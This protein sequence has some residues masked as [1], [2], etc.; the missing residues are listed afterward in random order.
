MADPLF[1]LAVVLF[2]ARLVLLFLLQ[3]LPGGV[4]PVRDPVSDYAVADA[5]RT[6][7]LAT[8]ASWAAAM[9][10]IALGSAV[11]LHT[12]LGDARAGLGFWLL[13]LGL[14]LAA[15]PLVPTDRTGSQV[16]LRGRVHLLA[17]VLW[18]TLAYST[19]GPLGRLVRDPAG[20]ILGVLDV[21][22]GL[23]LAALVI[24]LV[25]RPLRNCAF[26]IV[27]RAFI[28]VV[29]VAPLVASIDLASR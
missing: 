23:T 26:G 28:L 24:A 7:V 21:A 27:E 9:A 18:F 8:T 3:L 17:A 25:L 5:A 19:I 20:Q 15:M 4:D 6:R 29:T 10:W 13:A 22:A 11:V 16:T 1:V 14:L 12:D 2:S